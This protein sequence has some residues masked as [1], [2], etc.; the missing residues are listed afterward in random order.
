MARCSHRFIWLSVQRVGTGTQVQV[1]LVDRAT[2][3]GVQGGWDWLPAGVWG[4]L[5]WLVP[6]GTT[7]TT[8]LTSK[9]QSTNTDSRAVGSV[10]RGRTGY[11]DR[12]TVVADS[13]PDSADE[14]TVGAANAITTAVVPVPS[15]ASRGH[16]FSY[17]L[18]D[19][20]SEDG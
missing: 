9:R 10:S 20:D 15:T 19:S 17:D 13:S 1:S 12:Y 11:V 2:A 3:A 16:L 8:L 6:A 4:E 14:R 18:P 7:F 5:E